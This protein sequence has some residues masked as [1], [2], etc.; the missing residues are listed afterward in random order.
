MG[1][2]DGGWGDDSEEVVSKPRMSCLHLHFAIW[3]GISVIPCL[4]PSMTSSFLA[5]PSI[6]DCPPPI[7]VKKKSVKKKLE[8]FI[9]KKKYLKQS[10][11]IKRAKPIGL[12]KVEGKKTFEK[13]NLTCFFPL[14]RE[15]PH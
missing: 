3:C 12:Q 10:L 4:R 5:F 2:E 9:F 1:M 8:K 6:R 13:K 11:Q 15:R 7:P 14:P